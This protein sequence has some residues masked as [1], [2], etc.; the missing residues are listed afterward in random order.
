MSHEISHQHLGQ[1]FDE[2][3]ARLERQFGDRWLRGRTGRSKVSIDRGSFATPACATHRV[4]ARPPSSALL[5]AASSFG[6]VGRNMYAI[7]CRGVPIRA[8]LDPPVAL[9]T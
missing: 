4:R 8:T 6:V 3:L 1:G 9:L 2:P 5:F 7:A